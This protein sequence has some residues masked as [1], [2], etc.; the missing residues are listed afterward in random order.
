MNRTLAIC[1]AVELFFSTLA[2]AALDW[3][4]P[5]SVVAAAVDASAR[6]RE[7][8]ARG[9]AARAQLTQAGALPNPTLLAGVQNEPVDLSRDRSFTMVTVGL[10]QLFLR[11]EERNTLR[12]MAEREVRRIDAEEQTLRAEIQLDVVTTWDEAA[13]AQN[14]INFSDELARLSAMLT[15]AARIRYEAGTGPQLDVIT[16][17][18]EEDHLRQFVL[19]ARGRHAAAVARLRA[20][21]AL[22]EEEVIPSFTTPKGH[23]RQTAATSDFTTRATDILDA[24][25]ATAESAVKLARLQSKPDPTIEFRYDYRPWQKSFFSILG[26]VELPL[27]KSTV[28]EPRIQAKLAQKEAAKARLEAVRQELRAELGA[29]IAAQTTAADQI[30]FHADTLVPEAKLAF[31]SALTSYQNGQ[32]GLDTVLSALRT[33]RQLNLDYFALLLRQYLAQDQIEGLLYGVRRV[34]V[35]WPAA[36]GAAMR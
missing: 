35:Q 25:V 6:L 10:S 19:D 14:Q 3:S 36:E 18:L 31:D 22:P 5:S 15:N 13:A 11:R 4:A 28:V 32:T 9:D 17:R 26:R 23:R 27:R 30:R 16:A 20:L 21:L 12:E 33:Y 8:R 2:M 24:E 34:A 7:V 1:V 29:A